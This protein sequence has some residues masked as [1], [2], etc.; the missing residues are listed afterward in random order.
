MNYFVLVL[1]FAQNC[2]ALNSNEKALHI[3]NRFA[4]GPKQGEVT[5]LAQLGDKGL[6][7]W[8]NH[9]INPDKNLNTKLE[10]KLKNLS[11]L[12]Y[13]NQQMLEA[14]PRQN[15]KT[16]LGIDANKVEGNP[17]DILIELVL[18]KIV[19][20]AESENLF[21]ERDLPVTTDFRDVFSEILKT[22]FQMS[23]LSKVFP[24]FKSR[25]LNLYRS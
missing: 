18:Q 10:E 20:A 4:Y 24:D 12:K 5:R 6:N 15:E 19:R 23:D 13:T 16:M 11:S 1:L 14:F 2:L 8:F 9:Q 7:D 25:R 22:Q 21:E 17:K 3:L